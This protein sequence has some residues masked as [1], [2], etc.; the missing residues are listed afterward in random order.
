MS[1]MINQSAIG[2]KTSFSFG[3]D[4]V[5]FVINDRTGERSYSVPYETLALDELSTVAMPRSEP[6]KYLWAIGFPMGF[7]ALRLGY[8]QPALAYAFGGLAF[9]AIFLGILSRDRKWFVVK[10]DLVPVMFGGAQPLRVLH[11]RDHARILNE[12]L[13]GQIR[14]LSKRD[15]LDGGSAHEQDRVRFIG[16]HE[17]DVANAREEADSP[18]RLRG[19]VDFAGSA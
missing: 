3:E 17:S 6:T 10:L 4:R 12:L 7:L 9:A 5:A 2:I 1:E 18:H 19:D 8:N 15:T 14:V 11:G 13:N 16:P